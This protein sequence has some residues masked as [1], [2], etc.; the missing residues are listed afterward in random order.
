MHIYIYIDALILLLLREVGGG[1]GGVEANGVNSEGVWGK[2]GNEG[3]IDV[4]FITP[5]EIV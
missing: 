2:G 3:L 5:K 1:N 4:A